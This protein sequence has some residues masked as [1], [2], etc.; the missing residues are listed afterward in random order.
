MVGLQLEQVAVGPDRFSRQRASRQLIRLLKP[1]LGRAPIPRG[2]AALF[3]DPPVYLR[4]SGARGP[5]AA[6]SGRG[7][8][9]TM[10]QRLWAMGY[11]AG[12][13]DPT[14][15]AMVDAAASTGTPR[16]G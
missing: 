16:D 10:V 1:Q 8:H 7:L 2:G 14:C 3:S 4:S 12:S 13:W 11:R 6:G 5:L 9:G 15:S